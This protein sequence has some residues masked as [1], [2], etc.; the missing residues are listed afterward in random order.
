MGALGWLPL[1]GDR[2][3]RVPGLVEVGAHA[4]GFFF[5]FFFF[6]CESGGSPLVGVPAASLISP[7]CF[8]L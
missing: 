3:C 5:F 7:A 4:G 6:F 8:A 1:A 2:I